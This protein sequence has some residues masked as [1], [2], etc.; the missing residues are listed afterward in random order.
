MSTQKALV[1][2]IQG[3]IFL[4]TAK[5]TTTINGYDFK[6]DET[7]FTDTSTVDTSRFEPFTFAV[8]KEYEDT[9]AR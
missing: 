5:G 3:M 4:N 7:E 6:S 1:K 2:S 8:F 9:T